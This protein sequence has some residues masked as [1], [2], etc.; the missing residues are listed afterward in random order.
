MS[1][2]SNVKM[3][4]QPKDL[5]I[6]LYPHQLASV[7]A[8]EQLEINSVIHKDDD[9]IIQTKIG[10]NADFTG[11]GK[12]IAMITLILRNQMEW[13]MYAPY[14]FETIYSESKSRIKKY[15]IKRYDKLNTTLILVSQSIITQWEKEIL[16]SP[17]KYS[18]IATTKALESVKVEDFDVI[19]TTP[20]MY[21][22]IVTIYEKFAWKRF[23][24][25][26]PA[27]LKVPGMREIHAGFY[28]FITA[29]PSGIKEFHRNCNLSFMRDMLESDQFFDSYYKDIIIKNDYEFVKQSFLMPDTIHIYHEIYDPLYLNF[30][31][32]VNPQ[33]RTL[34]EAGNIQEAITLLGGGKTKNLIEL[35]KQKKLEELEEIE[36]KITIYTMRDDIEKIDKWKN[37]KEHILLQIDDVDEKFNNMLNE[38][39]RICF[40]NMDSPVL[41]YNCQN[42]FC[43][44]CLL[45]WLEN[46]KHCPM[47]RNEID[48][49]KLVYVENS[50]NTKPPLPIVKKMTKIEKILDIIE[51]TKDG[52]FLIFSDYDSTFF[53]ISRALTENSISYIE[54]KGN[55]KTRERNLD[56]FKNGKIPVIFINSTFN[57][58]GLNIVE[59]TDIILCHDMKKSSE[60]QIIGRANRIGRTT[61]VNVH[62]LKITN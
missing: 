11:Y 14:V 45:K 6:N 5:T 46:K 36:S 20:S 44:Q 3:I 42:L 43:G 37:K 23:I 39:C 25:D 24:F 31:D 53:S 26:E 21:N 8:M 61:S 59:A 30:K 49:T 1:E 9:T 41:E 47:C 34:I 60:N 38:P 52:K 57:C 54:I 28:W 7:Y 35:I 33:I 12:T 56:L 13:D 29:T 16:K 27:H 15:K 40:E 17:L 19:L 18:I 48:I 22:R 51:S 10:I 55:I 2:Y 62:H 50:K 4:K 32:I 58:S